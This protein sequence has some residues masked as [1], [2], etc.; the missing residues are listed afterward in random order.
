MNFRFPREQGT[1]QKAEGHVF[2]VA[3][4]AERHYWLHGLL[5]P[6]N[7]WPRKF[8]LS[9]VA[10]F[11][12][13]WKLLATVLGYEKNEGKGNRFGKRALLNC[14]QYKTRHISSPGPLR[15]S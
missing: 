14:V 6:E 10:V 5:P 3:C 4:I 2:R 12:A 11:T 15:R 13:N 1:L 7:V 8:S 9:S